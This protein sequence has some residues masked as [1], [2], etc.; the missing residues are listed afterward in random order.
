MISPADGVILRL[1]EPAGNAAVSAGQALAGLAAGKSPL[2]AVIDLPE[3]ALAYVKPGQQVQFLFAAYSHYR[4][5]VRRGSD[6]GRRRLD[7]GRARRA[8]PRYDARSNDERPRS[9][10]GEGLVATALPGF[11]FV[12][13]APLRR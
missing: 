12:V 10:A 8:P 4:F 9:I 5:G 2:Q 11:R 13:L 7:T 3:D 6:R 1:E